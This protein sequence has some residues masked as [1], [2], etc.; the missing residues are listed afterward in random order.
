MYNPNADFFD[1]DKTIPNP[2][3]IEKLKRLYPNQYPYLEIVSTDIYGNPEEVIMNPYPWLE[4]AYGYSGYWKIPNYSNYIIDEHGNIF[5]DIYNRYLIPQENARGYKTI[6]L[7]DDQGNVKELLIHRLVASLF[8]PESRDITKLQVNHIDNNH[9]NNHVSNLEWCTQKENIN[10][11]YQNYSDRRWIKTEVRNIHTGEIFVFRNRV[12]ASNFLNKPNKDWIEWVLSNP[13]TRIWEGT[14]QIRK[15]P[16][17]YYGF[18][19]PTEDDIAIASYNIGTSN[20]IDL[21]NC[22]TGEVIHF[23]RQIDCC[24]Y[25]NLSAPALSTWINNTNQNV[26]YWNNC[27]WQVKNNPNLDWFPVSDPYLQ[28]SQEQQFE[29]VKVIYPD[30]RFEIYLQA[31]EC[32]KTHGLRANTLNERLKLNNPNKFWKDGKAYVRYKNFPGY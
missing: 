25:L 17:P 32:A 30:G 4:P 6:S 20:K 26:F 10:H 13:E 23:E 2:D 19:I 11:Y 8:I 9:L 22:L 27:I 5:N 7:Y 24:N 21:R 14:Y 3:N 1:E 31:A 12:E 28:L 18:P 29:P 15:M 16:D